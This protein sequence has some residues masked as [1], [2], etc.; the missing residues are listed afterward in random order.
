MSE[1]MLALMIPLVAIP[2]GCLT[3]V[4]IAALLFPT[5]RQA[6]A[7][8]I[9]HRGLAGADPD[10]AGQLASAN[11]QLA[12]LRGEVYALRCEVATIAQVLPAPAS[13]PALPPGGRTS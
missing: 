9:G 4:V 2:L 8:R 12:A 13:P 7:N 1:D 6:L 10:V 5:T 11:A 3:M